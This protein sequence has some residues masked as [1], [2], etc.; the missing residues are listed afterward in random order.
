[1]N[2]AERHNNRYTK[3][4][5]ASQLTLFAGRLI[6]AYNRMFFPYHKWFYH[7]LSKCHERPEGLI[8]LMEALLQEP[9]TKNSNKLFQ[10]IK[11]FKDWRVSDIEAFSW[12]MDEVECG[13]MENPPSLEDW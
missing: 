2:E 4:R 13:W 3:V 9:N 1:M 5:A 7:Y 6:L 12:F 8:N 10:A 11:E